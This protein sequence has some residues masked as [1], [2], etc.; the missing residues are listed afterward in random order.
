MENLENVHHMDHYLIEVQ[1]WVQ[2][3]KQ[4]IE[5]DIKTESQQERLI[6]TII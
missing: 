3:Q 4:I 5:V 2:V 6:Y 1:E